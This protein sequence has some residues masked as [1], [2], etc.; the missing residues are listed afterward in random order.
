MKKRKPLKR[1]SAA[2]RAL[3]KLK[4]KTIPNKKRKPKEKYRPAWKDADGFVDFL[5]SRN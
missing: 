5:L 3:T 4:S 2:A 1:R